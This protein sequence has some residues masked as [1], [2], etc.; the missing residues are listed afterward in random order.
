M[1]NILYFWFFAILAGLCGL[2]VIISRNPMRSAVSL[3]ITMVCIAAL[4]LQLHSEFLAY[5]QIIV[6]AGA[7]MVLIVFTVSLLNLQREPPIVL[8]KSRQWGIVFVLIFLALFCVY[9]FIDKSYGFSGP[10]RPP[11]PVEW[12]SVPNVARVL[13][14]TY[15]LP[16]ELVSVLLTGAIIGSA[17]LARSEDARRGKGGES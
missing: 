17:V 2:G 13:F 12:G 3:V 15:L 1:F 10:P 4:F 7:V 6:Y 11:V 9:Q 5:L 16:F 14:T 8:R